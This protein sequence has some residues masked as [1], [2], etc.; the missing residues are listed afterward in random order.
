MPRFFVDQSQL[1]SKFLTL[2]GSNAVH[3][4]VLRLKQGDHV[5]L[6]DGHGMEFQC[7]ISDI[8]AHQVCLIIE[9][10]MSSLSEAAVDVT[11]YMAYAKGDKLE[12]V[13]QKATELGAKS[14]VTY[15]SSRSI[16]RMDKMQLEKKL[17]RW[18]KIAL[19]AAE[20]SGRGIIP[21]IR[22]LLSYEEALTQAAR[23]DRR[24]FFYENEVNHK[25]SDALSGTFKSVSLM[26]GPEGGYSEAETALA[27]NYGM[28]ICSLGRRIL[29]CE[30][31]PLCALAAVMYVSGE[32]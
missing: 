20:Q 5:T 18:K 11:V 29:R 31:A 24:L 2:D 3:A 12:H 15:P 19:A 30:T 25:L 32:Y 4:K 13:I 14:I 28:E 1:G 23:A 9:E 27:K 22:G 16:V 17:P 10:E 7:T 8:S 6:C 21:D 26:T